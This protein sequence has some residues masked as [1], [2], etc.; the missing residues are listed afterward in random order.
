MFF[1]NPDYQIRTIRITTDGTLSASDVT[2]AVNIQEGDSLLRVNLQSVRAAVESL[3]QV[4]SASVTRTLPSELAIRIDER[5]P[6]ARV[7]DILA[8][9]TAEWVID[10][11]G[12][13]LPADPASSRMAVLPGIQLPG[14][15]EVDPGEVLSHPM[16]EPCL[17]LL[18]LHAVR[19]QT[20]AEPTT[21]DASKAYAL[22]CLY[23][24]GM[25]VLF[26][27]HDLALQFHRLERIVNNAARHDQEV[28]SV[29]LLAQDNLPVSLRTRPAT[30]TASVA[31]RAQPR[32]P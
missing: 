29:N 31:P 12:V 21:V 13:V 20:F 27:P 16:L 10:R 11:R 25:E 18:E 28:A 19:Q 30:G 24:D 8:E 2:R 6:A 32:D 22:H 7:I 5:R 26:Q 3:P 9:E 1:D 14:V 4:Q 15:G 23:P 17:E